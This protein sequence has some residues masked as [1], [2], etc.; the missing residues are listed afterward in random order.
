MENVFRSVHVIRDGARPHG[1]HAIETLGVDAWKRT[2]VLVTSL[3]QARGGRV[4][5]RRHREDY[6]LYVV[7]V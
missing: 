3:R 4:L 2:V 7:G 5:I 1:Q 6:G